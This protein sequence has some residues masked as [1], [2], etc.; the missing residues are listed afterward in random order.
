MA[1]ARRSR[2]KK[3]DK[4]RTSLPDVREESR[5]VLEV[6][7]SPTDT[8]AVEIETQA[9][10]RFGAA[11]N[12][13]RE[14]NVGQLVNIRFPSSMA[15]EF[16]GRGGDPL[17][18]VCL[19]QQGNRVIVDGQSRFHISVAFVG[20]TFPDSYNAD[21]LQ[22]YA[23]CGSH[24]NGFFRITESEQPFKTRRHPRFR[25]ELELSLV[26]IN[27]TDKTIVKATGFSKNI[28]VSG[29]SVISTLEAQIGDKIKVGSIDLDFYGIAVVRNRK[30]LIGVKNL[31][32]LEFLDS[33]FPTSRVSS[34]LTNQQEFA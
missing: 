13:E 1:R 16:F 12:I 28:S 22:S 5:V 32:H 21:P 34:F 3:K 7:Y 20:E 24:E 14:C 19:V 15:D 29:L 33:D 25:F 18:I 4:G 17:S 10:S 2:S 27:K 11:F 9:L 23:V 26:H 31:L 30:S 6:R 8:W